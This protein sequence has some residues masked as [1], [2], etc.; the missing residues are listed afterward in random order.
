MSGE[1]ILLGAGGHGVVV[2]ALAR[3]LGWR[4]AGVCDPALAPGSLWEDVPVL[5]DDAALAARDPAGL[6]LLNGLGKMPGATARARLQAAWT[7]RGATF[8]PLVHPAAWVAPGV[9][10]GAGAQVMAG[11]VVQPRCRIGAGC[12]VNTRASLDHDGTLGAD[13]HLAP[14]A[15]L[16]GGV[17]VGEGA[18]IG[19]GATVIQGLRIGAGAMVAAGAV[20]VQDVPL[21][22]RADRP[23][24]PP[25]GKPLP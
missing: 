4:V 18:F 21:G 16:C 17:T 13:V 15:T 25:D 12:I 11:A 3:A 6:T 24:C 8:P 9:A 2:L 19:A 14:G 5:G 22:G 20:V 1:A 7:A 10:L 23:A